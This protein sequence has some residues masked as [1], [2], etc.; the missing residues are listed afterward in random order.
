M[1]VYIHESVNPGI[2]EGVY[3]AYQEMN[4]NFIVAVQ[5]FTYELLP[6]DVQ[7]F[8]DNTSTEIDKKQLLN[9]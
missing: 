9:E 4:G 2:P 6:S 3:E 7:V 8:L 5:G 1:R